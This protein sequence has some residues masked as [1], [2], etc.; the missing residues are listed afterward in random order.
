MKQSIIFCAVMIAAIMLSCKQE[1]ATQFSNYDKYS[2][3][4]DTNWVEVT[5]TINVKLKCLDLILAKNGVVIKSEAD[6]Q[7]LWNQSIETIRWWK[8][9]PDPDTIYQDCNNYSPINID[10]DKFSIL[11][12]TTI[13]GIAETV[14]NIYINDKSKTYLHL[15]H[16]TKIRL[17]ARGDGYFNWVSIPKV[18]SGYQV[19]FDTTWSYNIK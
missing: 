2:I 7:N 10:F 9:R 1:H 5:D 16:I 8:D 13:T 19:L 3:A 14:R 4:N 18:K 11:G 12:Y 15:V 17:E 6:Y